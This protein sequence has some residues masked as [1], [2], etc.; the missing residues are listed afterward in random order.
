[1]GQT[2]SECQAI[3]WVINDSQVKIEAADWLPLN[4]AGQVQ[5]GMDAQHA[6]S[7]AK[8]G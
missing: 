6:S 4:A 5:E 8:H 7:I 1:M 3:Q 2:I